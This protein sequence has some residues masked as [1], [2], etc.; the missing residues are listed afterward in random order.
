MMPGASSMPPSSG[1]QQLSPETNSILEE[2]RKRVASYPKQAARPIRL[3]MVVASESTSI[4]SEFLQA[5]EDPLED[6]DPQESEEESADKDKTAAGPGNKKQGKQDSGDSHPPPAT[7]GGTFAPA[8]DSE[9][10]EE[11]RTNPGGRP[12]TQPPPV[13]SPL[14][15]ITEAPAKLTPPPLDDLSDLLSPSETVLPFSTTTPESLPLTVPPPSR[16]GPPPSAR[17]NVTEPHEDKPSQPTAVPAPVSQPTLEQPGAPSVPTGLLGAPPELPGKATVPG[18]P[19]HLASALAGVAD[20]IQKR[21][22]G[23]V[24]Q[25]AD[26]G[27]RRIVLTDGDISIVSSSL[28]SESLAHFLHERGDYTDDVL[29]SL[30]SVSNFG[31][32]AGAALIARGLLQQEDL[33]PVLRAHAEWVLGRVLTS[34]QPTQF[35]ETVPARLLEEPAVF[36]GAAGTEIFLEAVRRVVSPNAALVGLDGEDTI[37]GLGK[38]EGLLNESALSS[39]D[40]HLVREAIGQPLSTAAHSRP[41]LLP[42]LFGFVA[43][44]ILSKGGAETPSL[45]PPNIEEKSQE[46]DEEAFAARVSARRALVDDGDYF[47]ILGVARSA[48]GYE[49]NRARSE[50]LSE[51]AD[52]H[53]TA[54]TVHLRADLDLLRSIINEAHLVLADDV[55]RQRYRRAL[56]AT[57]S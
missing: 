8:S 12:P 27:I 32:H 22:T 15:S 52:E 10:P 55:R 41:E 16:K 49:V 50:L 20:A 40:Q 6:D 19:P 4:R 42:V 3:P 37:L 35:E 7:S 17:T 46:I 24:A 36:G 13:D 28:S 44:G 38:H 29:A 1:R 45:P 23:A 56:E 53:L 47:S 39:D 57:P 51:Y 11:E 18:T 48:T 2:G 30:G 31:R 33:W 5:L 25:Q 14:L 54:R 21:L 26:G 43:L 9:S 34:T